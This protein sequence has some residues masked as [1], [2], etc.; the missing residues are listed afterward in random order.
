MGA[1]RIA[2]KLAYYALYD[3]FFESHNI[4]TYHPDHLGSSNYITDY[5]GKV[6]EHMEYTPYGESWID[7]GSNTSVVPFKFTGK[8]LDAETGLY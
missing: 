8:E 7:D 6:F 1:T 2:S 5:A 4:Y 3:S